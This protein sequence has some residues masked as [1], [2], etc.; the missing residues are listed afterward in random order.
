MC[1]FPGV[2]SHG[3]LSVPIPEAHN[4]LDLLAAA[5][6][7]AATTEQSAQMEIEGHGDGGEF[8]VPR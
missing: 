2:A 1:P 8:K 6:A 4:P 3:P 5:A 7:A